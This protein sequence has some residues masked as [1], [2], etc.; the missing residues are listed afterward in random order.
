MPTLI[1]KR[2]VK[3]GY[4]K[5]YE[6]IL[7]N[8]V[9]KTESMD[10]YMGINIAR[11]VN[12][13]YPLYVFSAKFDTDENLEK[14]KNSRIR[15]ETLRALHDVTQRP[16]TE[17]TLKGLAWWFAMP[18]QYTEVSKIKMLIITILGAYPI[19]LVLNILIN[20]K[21][22]IVTLAINTF[23]IILITI[24]TMTYITLPILIKIFTKWLY[25][26]EDTI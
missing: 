7:S 1:V 10:G 20:S 5:N 13:N 21:I 12:K 9:E 26:P 23:F 8:L 22:S 17:H 6:H 15:Q 4:E 19:V 11:P 16:I 14:F 25:L 24:V 18:A 2:L 3:R